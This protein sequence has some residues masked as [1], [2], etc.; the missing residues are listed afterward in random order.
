M[1]RVALG[2]KGVPRQA[3]LGKQWRWEGVGARQSEPVL[4]GGAG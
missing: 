1:H 4:P 3:V 2:G